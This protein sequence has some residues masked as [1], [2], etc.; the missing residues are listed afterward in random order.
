MS[1]RPIRPL[2]ALADVDLGRQRSP[3]HEQ[4]PHMVPYLRAAN[5]SDGCL[6]LSDIK[7]MNFTPAEQQIFSLAPGDVL[8]TEGSGSLRSVGASAVW[9][10]EIPGTVC[11]QNTLL[12]L[13]PKDGKTDP[14]YLAWW[15][16]AAFADGLFASI[17]SGANIFHLSADRVRSLSLQCPPLE[18]QREIANKLEAETDRLD[19]L[20][21]KRRRVINLFLEQD[22]AIIDH[23]LDRLFQQFGQMPFGRG[24]QSIE[25]GWS[26][27]CHN[28]PAE[29]KEWGVLKV[30]AVKNGK[31]VES[32][33]KRLPD[34]L[35]PDLLYRVFP[36]DLLITRANTPALVGAVAIVP[37]ISSNLLL[38]DKI[39]RVNVTDKIDPELFVNLARSSRVRGLCAAASHGTSHSMVNIKSSDIKQ[40]PV[41]AASRTAQ[42]ESAIMLAGKLAKSS[43]LRVLYTKQVDLLQEH[44][45]AL[46]TAAVLGTA[47]A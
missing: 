14:R 27:Q 29:G 6:N 46:I 40:W 15:A 42:R 11:F 44:R 12:R 28:V 5:V 1:E 39:F 37:E 41:P 9:S 19:A 43:R 10:G 8:V 4:G 32:E 34:D 2:R 16:R 24:I 17:A 33:N 23:E 25:Q 7:E 45:K 22:L 26:P 30:S 47:L 21:A 18:W 20:I 31:F 35:A 3:Q 13:R 36:G 38:C